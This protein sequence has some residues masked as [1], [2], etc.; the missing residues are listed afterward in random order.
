MLAITVI[1]VSWTE[2]YLLVISFRLFKQFLAFFS[3]HNMSLPLY[4]LVAAVGRTEVIANTLAT[5]ILLIIMS[6]GGFV[7]AKGKLVTFFSLLSYFF[8][9]MN[10][11][12]IPL[13]EILLSLRNN[14]SVQAFFSFCACRWHWAIS[15]MGLLYFPYDVWT[16]CITC[17]WIPWWKMGGSKI[18]FAFSSCDSHFIYWCKLS[19]HFAHINIGISYFPGH[20]SSAVA[21]IF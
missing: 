12:I 3:I 7:M 8:W 6:L 4:R 14:G 21:H 11:K 15:E 1:W 10:K 2:I 20:N 5:F 19:M 16:D 9:I 17:K 18:Y 13:I